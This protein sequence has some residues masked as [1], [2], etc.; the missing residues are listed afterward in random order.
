MEEVQPLATSFDNIIERKSIL[1]NINIKMIK[2]Q[3]KIR[4][5][6]GAE[7]RISGQGRGQELSSR[8]RLG[9]GLVI[10]SRVR[11]ESRILSQGLVKNFLKL[12]IFKCFWEK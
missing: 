4:I 6:V 2:N 1:L 5:Q 10:E 12:Y 3:H 9:S 8:S 7:S 11:V